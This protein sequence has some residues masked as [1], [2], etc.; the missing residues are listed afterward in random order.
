MAHS[1]RRDGATGSNAEH[2]IIS[3]PDFAEPAQ[4]QG[5]CALPLV[6]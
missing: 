2:A 4:F 1:S 3:C 6:I 5:I